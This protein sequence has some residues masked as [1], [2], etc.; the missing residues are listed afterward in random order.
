LAAKLHN[1]YGSRDCTEMACESP[2]MARMHIYAN[3]VLVE[4]VDEQ[5]RAVQPGTAGRLLVT[6]PEQLLLPDDPLRDR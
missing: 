2:S 3:H 1:K 4:V 6:L 5:G